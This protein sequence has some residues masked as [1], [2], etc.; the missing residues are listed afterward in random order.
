MTSFENFMQT[1]ISNNSQTLFGIFLTEAPVTAIG[2][3]RI[4]YFCF[5]YEEVLYPN[6]SYFVFRRVQ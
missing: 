3:W 5:S 4:A 1:L 6:A 2:I